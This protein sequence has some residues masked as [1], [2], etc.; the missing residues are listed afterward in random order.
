MSEMSV[1]V[2][3]GVADGLISRPMS[4]CVVH[5]RHLHDRMQTVHFTQQC[6]G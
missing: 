5:R 2:F 4:M 1:S 6:Y 3:I